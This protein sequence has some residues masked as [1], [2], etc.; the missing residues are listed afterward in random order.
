MNDQPL[1]YLHGRAAPIVA[2]ISRLCMAEVAHARLR[3]ATASTMAKM[4]GA[5]YRIP[6]HP[7]GPGEPIDE[8]EFAVITDMPVKSLITAPRRI[9]SPVPADRSARFRLERSRA[10]RVGRC[11]WTVEPHGARRSRAGRA[12]LRVAAIQ[13]RI[14][15][16]A[17]PLLMISRATDAKAAANRLKARPGTRAAIATTRCTACRGGSTE[18]NPSPSL[19]EEGRSVSHYRLA[20][21]ARNRT[22][23]RLRRPGRG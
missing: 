16:A 3:C 7:I 8:S 5:E 18:W 14:S 21:A 13:G 4:C 9:S 20:P 12:S 23:P 11:F 2:R 22:S 15:R 10:G 1:P 6:T 19:R 17:G